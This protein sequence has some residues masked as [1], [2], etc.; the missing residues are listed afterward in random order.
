VAEYSETELKEAA[1]YIRF[2]ASIRLGILSFFSIF[3]AGIL[4]FMWDASQAKQTGNLVQMV[5]FF[6]P[7]LGLLV[8]IFASQVD[9]RIVQYFDTTLKRA[10]RLEETLRIQ[11][12][13]HWRFRH[14]PYPK[15]FGVE[16]RLRYLAEFSY[17]IFAVIFAI[18]LIGQIIASTTQGE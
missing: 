16:A 10:E 15:I 2:F 18:I 6:L 8:S 1:T 5:Q 11:Q 7:T 17:L 4:R 13:L 12:G 3:M 14:V 9:S